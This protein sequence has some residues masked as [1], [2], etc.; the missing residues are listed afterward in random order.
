MNSFISSLICPEYFGKALLE[1]CDKK[2]NIDEVSVEYVLLL[3]VRLSSVMSTFA[4]T[5]YDFGTTG[6]FLRIML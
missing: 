2:G 5:V 1:P 3:T 6:D 4:G